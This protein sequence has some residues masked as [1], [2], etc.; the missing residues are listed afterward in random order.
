MRFCSAAGAKYSSDLGMWLVKCSEVNTLPTLTF[1]ISGKPF[2]LNGTQYTYAVIDDGDLCALSISGGGDGMW[3]LGDAF[4]SKYYSVYDLEKNQ[5]GFA[6]AK[7][8]NEIPAVPK[9]VKKPGRV[10][11][12]QSTSDHQSISDYTDDEAEVKEFVKGQSTLLKKMKEFRDSAQELLD[13]LG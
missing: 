7:S 10:S 11:Q 1:T 4:L 8:W 9:A 3:I 2:T 13:L 12:G 5:V 6:K